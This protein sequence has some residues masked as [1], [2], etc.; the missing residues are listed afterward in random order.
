MYFL[1]TF[2]GLSLENGGEPPTGAAA[3][4]SRLALLAVLA[5]AGDRGVSRDSLQAL[6]WPESDTETARGALNQALYALRRDLGKQDLT[7]GSTELVLNPSVIRSDVQ[8]F[9]QALERGELER[10]AALYRGKF[11]EGVNINGGEFDR[12]LDGQRR[13][14]HELYQDA[15]TRLARAAE[16]RSDHPE[17]VRWRRALATADPLSGLVAGSLMRA[18]VKTGDSAAA[19]RHALVYEQMVKSELDA[20]PDKSVKDLA[21][22]I[23]RADSTPLQSSLSPQPDGPRS[24]QAGSGIVRRPNWLG[25]GIALAALGALIW[26][27][28]EGGGRTRLDPDRVV[29]TAA[30]GATTVPRLDSVLLAELTRGL[31]ERDQA[32]KVSLVQRNSQSAVRTARAAGAR[33]VVQV[34]SAAEGDSV[35]F[36]ASVTDAVSE[37]MLGPIES[38]V[39]L[40]NAS[41]NGAHALRDRVAVILAAHRNPLFANWAYAAQ[42]PYSWESFQQMALGIQAFTG[43][44]ARGVRSHFQTAATLDSTSA[45]P[46]LWEAFVM[47]AWGRPTESDSILTAAERS[48]RRF[49]PWE[50]ALGALLRV[51]T[52]GNPPGAAAGPKFYDLPGAHAAGHRLLEVVPG[53]EW[54]LL[55]ARDA[56]GLGRARE[57]AELSEAV[58]KNPG[59]SK[60]LRIAFMTREQ[61]YHIMGDFQREL[62][63]VREE[64]RRNPDSR[65]WLQAEVKALA[66][67]GRVSEVTAICDRAVSLRPEADIVEW[68]PCDQAILELA[69]HGHLDAARTLARRVL[70]AREAA[71]NTARDRAIV[72][73]QL[74]ETLADWEEVGKAL[75]GIPAETGDAD[76]LGLLSEV[77]AFHGDRLGVEQ[78]LRRL[79]SLN[80]KEASPYA[81][82]YSY[83]LAGV[84]AL[85]GDRDRAID[86][87]AKAFQEGFGRIPLHWAG[88]FDG[89]RGDPRFNA[90]ARPVEDPEH[91][92]RFA[93]R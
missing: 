87:L 81:G 83:Q 12:W 61:A 11:L 22:E 28:A 18:L 52:H 60:D 50:R 56:L 25:A 33:Y 27:L 92:A 58:S 86:L 20:P 65:L 34:G 51:R 37:T 73:A 53:S 64:L 93:R 77:Q 5:A 62:E 70:P 84:A 85:L 39:V 68:W 59:W 13:R 47:Q 6:F 29:L 14:L 91:L 72:R 31:M 46:L 55:L 10:A 7:T 82:G 79:D 3:Q 36:V 57:A 48:S 74:Y 63:V 23:G 49:G 35:R 67:L 44:D 69:A 4:R 89:L 24:D 8:E 30:A 26:A 40:A 42:L 21:A 41:A 78:T 16:S 17:A 66:G 45:A 9:N 90:L 75:R 32:L 71:K 43:D 54:A 15:L 1:R 76:Y 38:V 2:G 19:L 80:A 88:P